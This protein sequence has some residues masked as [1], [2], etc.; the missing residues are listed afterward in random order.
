[1]IDVCLLGTGGTVPLPNRYLTSLYVRW[2]G[3]AVLVDCGEG[4]QIAMNRMCLS[5]KQ[6]DTILLTHFHADHTAGLPG[7]LLTM[8][9]QERTEPITI[10]GPKGLKEIMQGVLIIARYVPFDICLRE[11]TGNTSVFSLFDM[12]VTAFSLRHSVPTYGYRMELKRSRRFDPEK[13]KKN[14]VPLRLWGLLQ[15]GQQAER[16]GIVYTPDMVLAEERKGISLVYATDTRPVPYIAQYAKDADLLITEGMY[17]D[18]EKIEKAKLNRHMLMGEAASIAA[19]ANA[20]ELW[21]THYSPSMHDPLL[22]EE[23]VRAVFRNTVISK[24]GQMKTLKFEEK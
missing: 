18:P 2:N 20:K 13:A 22:Y 24:D 9:K 12:E 17:G 14:G 1:M 8:A 5:G 3:H 21:L 4:T 16:D 19:S 11:I 15:K 6:I 10:I 7:L 23:D